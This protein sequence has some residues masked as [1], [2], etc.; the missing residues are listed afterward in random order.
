MAW[1]RIKSDRRTKRHRCQPP[2]FWRSRMPQHRGNGFVPSHKV[3]DP[4]VG[5]PRNRLTAV[6]DRPHADPPLLRSIGRTIEQATPQPSRTDQDQIES[7]HKKHPLPRRRDC[8]S[9]GVCVCHSTGG[10]WF[11]ASS[12]CGGS[13]RPPRNRLTAVNDRQPH[14]HAPS[15]RDRQEP[16]ARIRSAS[17]TVCE[18]RPLCY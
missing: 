13:Q 1:V 16:V 9:F 8:L 18:L 14:R 6:N 11:G 3:G 7:T 17:E 5:S 4:N 15:L 12:Q 10:N 2:E